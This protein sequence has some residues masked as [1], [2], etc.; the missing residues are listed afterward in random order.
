MH[1]PCN[2][3]MPSRVVTQMENTLLLDLDVGDGV[4]LSNIVNALLD[5]L[6]INHDG[7]EL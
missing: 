3:L 4:S 2:K 1:V 7:L 6:T 5:Y